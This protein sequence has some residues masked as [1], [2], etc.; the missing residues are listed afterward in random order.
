[1]VRQIKLRS[2]STRYLVGRIA[3]CDKYFDLQVE[4]REFNT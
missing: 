4:G 1:M 2:L 3:E